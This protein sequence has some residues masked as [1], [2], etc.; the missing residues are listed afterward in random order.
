MKL[1]SEDW[2]IKISIGAIVFLQLFAW[3]AELSN[4]QSDFHAQVKLKVW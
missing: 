4:M 1:I 3:I 2:L